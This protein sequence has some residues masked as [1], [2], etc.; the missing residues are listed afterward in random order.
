MLPPTVN[1]F[2]VHAIVTFVMSAPAVVPDP[3]MMVHVWL[4]GGYAGCRL[5]V[6][7]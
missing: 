2:V 1:A 3:F 6:I 7:A 5:T 4:R